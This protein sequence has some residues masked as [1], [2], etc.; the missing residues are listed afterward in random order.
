MNVK[1]SISYTKIRQLGVGAGMNS[2]VFLAND[3]QL[4][5][6]VAV[7]EI[8]TSKLVNPNYFAEA[9]TMYAV[10]HK[11]VV[12]IHYA[13]STPT[14]V[15]LA[16]PFY[17]DGSVEDRINVAPLPIG[18]VL[19]LGHD[20]LAAVAHTHIK[21]VLHLDIKPSNVFYRPDG[22]AL[23]A[24]FGQS[25]Q[26]TSTRTVKMPPMYPTAV[27]P[28]TKLRGSV[29]PEADIYQVG[30]LLYRAVNG[31]ALYR[32]QKPP[33]HLLARKVIDGKFPRRDKFM[34][35]VPR[36]LRTVIKKAL[37]ILPGSRY[38][39]AAE[40]EQALCSVSYDIE[41][42]TT[43][44]PSNGFQWTGQRDGQAP[45]E[46]VLLPQGKLWEVQVHTQGATKRAKGRT[47]YWRDGLKRVAALNHLKA[48]F[49][50]LS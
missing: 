33:L 36:R 7:K 5:A 27:P 47:D 45:I 3:P 35:H 8:E 6:D 12:P 1:A 38:S 23:L 46:V 39:S 40:M 21:N 20:M 42:Q 2:E 29:S 25:R 24:D 18:Q 13:C 49:Q 32:A 43:T 19:K 28:E 14:H 48:V 15:C 34:P 4:G 41:W 22:S 31:N 17:P 10:A 50:D 11:N 44:L 16:M 26:M 30:V 9:Q 37:E